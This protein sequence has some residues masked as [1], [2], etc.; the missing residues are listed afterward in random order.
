MRASGQTQVDR[1]AGDAR[2]GHPQPVA[3]ETGVAP[4]VPS[5]LPVSA[6]YH[7]GAAPVSPTDGRA[8]APVSHIPDGVYTPAP[9][10]KEAFW[11]FSGA[12]VLSCWL[13]C[14]TSQL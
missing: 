6:N 2:G 9:S 5:S 14:S 11:R 12:S 8:A 4:A 3:P 13:G 1:Q 10:P 7:R